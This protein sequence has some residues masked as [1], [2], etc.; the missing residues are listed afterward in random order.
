LKKDKFI[1][2]VKKFDKTKILVIGDI[3]I[4]RFI[5]GNVSRISPEA[6][7]P[8]VEV[9][10]ENFMPGGAGNVVSN[11]TSLGGEAYLAGLIGND[12]YGSTFIDEMNDRGVDCTSVITANNR[13]TIVKTRII[14]HH[15]QIVRVDREIRGNIDN[16]YIEQLIDNIK[17]IVPKI[18]AIIISDYG[19]GVINPKILSAVISCAKQ[20]NKPILV[21]PKIEHFKK[22][23]NVTCITPNTLEAK[24]G[25]NWHNVET[26]EDVEILGKKI[27]KTLNIPSL[28]ITQG[29][30]GMTIFEGKN[31]SH[32]PTMAKEVYDVTG[33]GDT[34]ISVLAMCLAN[35]TSVKD[36]AYIANIAAGI[37]VGKLGT[38]TVTQ[39]EIIEKI[40]N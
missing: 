15:Q 17:K 4:D 30:K 31:I 13:P 5:W 18:N 11:I 16:K 7:V 34:V 2:I 40:E 29:E 6:P 26:Q 14:A 39:D 23:K 25:M 28:L 3:M 8:V 33:A 36:G 12:N 27:M 19:K 20:F 22:Y 10:R 21:D 1:N 38:A 24:L 32:I 9:V 37:V 35:K